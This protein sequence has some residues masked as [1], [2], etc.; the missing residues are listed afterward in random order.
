MQSY[1]EQ[2]Y[3]N[4]YVWWDWVHLTDYGHQAFAGRIYPIIAKTLEKK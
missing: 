4:G 2:Q 3:E 1:L